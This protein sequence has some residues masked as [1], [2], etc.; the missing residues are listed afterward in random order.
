MLLVNGV[1][2]MWL[3]WKVEIK[4]LLTYWKEELNSNGIIRCPMYKVGWIL[5]YVVYMGLCTPESANVIW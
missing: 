3:L 5:L 2:N 1:A 4:L